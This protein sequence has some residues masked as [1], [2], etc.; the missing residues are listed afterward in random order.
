MSFIAFAG[1]TPTTLTSNA[2]TEQL[3]SVGIGMG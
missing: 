2:T 3:A 1:A